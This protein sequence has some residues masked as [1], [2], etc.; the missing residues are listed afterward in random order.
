MKKIIILGL[1]S[2]LFVHATNTFAFAGSPALALGPATPAQLQQMQQQ[3]TQ[4]Q[5][6]A[7][8]AKAAAQFQFQPIVSL[9]LPTGGVLGGTVDSKG[10]FTPATQS[11]SIADYLNAL[12]GLALGASAILAVIMIVFE[13]FKYMTSDAI[14][15]K[16]DA[17]TGLRGAT[18]GL[19]LLLMIWLIVNVINPQMLN[20]GNL[21]AD[22]SGLTANAPAGSGGVTPAGTDTKAT[23]PYFEPTD[24]PPGTQTSIFT[25]GST[26][27]SGCEL[28]CATAQNTWSSPP[29]GPG[30]CSTD[31]IPIQV[32]PK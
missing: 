28:K 19:I 15:S 14:G 27:G 30:N 5:Q 2:L 31:T 11:T 6:N 7:D 32:C 25:T 4:A 22:L 1:L 21:E 17:L 9:P 13:G 23:D 10:N 29:S 16:K 26:L 3:S 8:T 12:F 18:F 24:L 20:L